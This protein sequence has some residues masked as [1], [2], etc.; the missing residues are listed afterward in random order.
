MQL[1]KPSAHV[2]G[3]KGIC[4]MY[5]VFE[6]YEG[7]NTYKDSGSGWLLVD[8]ISRTG[9]LENIMKHWAWLTD[10]DTIKVK[11]TE[12]LFECSKRYHFLQCEDWGN[13]EAALGIIWH[14]CQAPRMVKLPSKA[15]DFPKRTCLRHTRPWRLDWC[16]PKYWLSIFLLTIWPC[17][18]GHS[19]LLRNI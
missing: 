6:K 17:K 3:C 5:Q 15:V 2:N 9:I 11:A 14:A 18:S 1:L 16:S 10:N 13:G 8:W 7:N 4:D 12:T 19:S